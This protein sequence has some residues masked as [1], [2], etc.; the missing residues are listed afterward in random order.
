M[1]FK[2]RLFAG[3]TQSYE[4]TSQFLFDEALT[5]L[6]HSNNPY[7]NRGTRN[8]RNSTDGIDN[9]LSTAEKSA[10]TLQT[11]A[12]ASGYAGVINLGV[13]VG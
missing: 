4:F 12:T 5:T 2:L 13:K 8:V 11:T 6:V 3:S 10:L 1:H 7:N 9:S